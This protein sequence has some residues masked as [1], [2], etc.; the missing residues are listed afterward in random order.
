[1]I[2]GSREY[3]EDSLKL[4]CDYQAALDSSFGGTEILQPLRAI[5]DKPPMTTH[6]RQVEMCRN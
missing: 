5:Y 1:M 6:S 2:R 3:S 4:A